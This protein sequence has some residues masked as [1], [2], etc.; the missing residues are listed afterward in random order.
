VVGL[1]NSG[2]TTMLNKM[3]NVKLSESDNVTAP[4]VGYNVEKFNKN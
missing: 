3:K 4:T 1:D 2:K